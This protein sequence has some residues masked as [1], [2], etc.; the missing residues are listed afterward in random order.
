M[1]KHTRSVPAVRRLLAVCA[2]PYDATFA[3]GGVIA[4]FADAGTTVHIVC[5]THGRHTDIE[6]RRRL[7]RARDLGRATRHLGAGDVTLLD[8]PPETLGAT[9]IDEL[10]DEIVEAGADADALLT[11]DATGSGAHPDHVRAMRAA[12]RAAIR[13]GSTLYAWTLRPPQPGQGHQVIVVDAD[14]ERQ[15]AAIACHTGLPADD[16]L[17]SRWLQHQQPDE[18]LVVLRTERVV[19]PIAARTKA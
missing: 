6:P 9:S 4:A 11:V 2:H 5:L 16:P 12:N 7:D 8:H 19:S 1:R 18:R 17:R 3:L 13:L 14:R 10:A 15:R